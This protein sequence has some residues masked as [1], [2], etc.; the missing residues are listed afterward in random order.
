[1]TKEINKLSMLKT[2]LLQLEAKYL[3]SPEYKLMKKFL[4]AQQELYLYRKFL[5]I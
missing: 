3:L 2:L 4:L 1:M 5:K